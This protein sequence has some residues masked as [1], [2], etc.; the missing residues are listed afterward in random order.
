MMFEGIDTKTWRNYETTEL[1]VWDKNGINYIYGA[2]TTDLVPVNTTPK[3][4]TSEVCFAS[5][6]RNMT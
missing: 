1:L 4:T 2:M 3:P 5:P 6:A